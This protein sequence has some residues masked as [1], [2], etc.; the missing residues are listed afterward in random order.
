MDL[1]YIYTTDGKIKGPDFFTE[2]TTQDLMGGGMALLSG[3]TGGAMSKLFGAAKDMFGAHTANEKGKKMKS[4]SADVVM[5]SGC[6][7]EQTVSSRKEKRRGWEN[8]LIV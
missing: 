8:E 2:E 3:D 4:S 6:K 7:D 5:W 1:P